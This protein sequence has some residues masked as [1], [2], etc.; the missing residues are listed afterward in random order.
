MIISCEQVWRE[1]S[2]YLD[3][4]VDPELRAA[5]EQHVRGCRRCTAVVDGMRNVTRLYRDERML[6]VP[7]GFS[8]RLHQRLENEVSS[9][10]RTFLGWMVAAAASLAVAGG[11]EIAR[12][13]VFSRTN[14]R[15][16]H[17]R[18][19]NRIP[20]DMMVIVAED[21]K[22]FHVPG[23]PFL[24]DKTRLRTISAR[25]AEQEGY[26]P[27]VR[28][29]QKY[30]ETRTGPVSAQD[31]KELSAHDPATKEVQA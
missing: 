13:S 16:K 2:D 29:M 22:T 21:G 3:G 18:L 5:I 14:L 23:C 15:S 25:R 9:S 28:C 11:I 24:H 7:A 10:R 4:E 26:A 1:I 27:C 30:M 12:S 31:K 6:E 19:S 8:R 17:P 20:P